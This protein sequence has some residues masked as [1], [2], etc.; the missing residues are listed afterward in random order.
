MERGELVRIDDQD[1]AS[2]MQDADR[3]VQLAHGC[4]S[5]MDGEK[6]VELPV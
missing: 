6:M 5:R 3:L 1:E 2:A 4:T